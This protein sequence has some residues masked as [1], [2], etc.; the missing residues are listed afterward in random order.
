M[1]GGDEPA[2]TIPC[3]VEESST[4]CACRSRRPAG[5]DVQVDGDNG[6]VDTDVYVNP[7]PEDFEARHRIRVE[8][9][10]GEVVVGGV[11]DS[12]GSPTVC[13]VTDACNALST[14]G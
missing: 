6:P 8:T 5:N 4:R 12:Q 11:S 1:T 14:N 7:D 9:P 3:V 2:T 10:V 13:R